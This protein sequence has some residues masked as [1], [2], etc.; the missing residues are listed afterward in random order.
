[1]EE[2]KRKIEAAMSKD[3]QNFDKLKQN[4]KITITEEGLRIE[5][6]ES[7]KG[8]FF[9]SGRSDPTKPGSE[10]LAM[11]GQ[12]LGELSNKVV[13]EGHT[14]SAPFGREDYGNW[15]LSSDRANMA[16]RL[17]HRQGLRPDQVVQVRGFA[18]QHLRKPE[19]PLDSSNRRV[20][21][22]VRFNDLEPGSSETSGS[23]GRPLTHK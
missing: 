23:P 17:M 11:L 15:E 3:I 14:D 1:M 16:R 4:V 22:I 9:E 8:V 21:V 2:L 6:L 18:D 10:I 7:E 12:Q 19:Y 13:V 5:L 20:S